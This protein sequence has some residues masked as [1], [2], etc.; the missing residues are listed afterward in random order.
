MV[1]VNV[2]FEVNYKF[3]I[4]Y[5]PNFTDINWIHDSQKFQLQMCLHIP[6]KTIPCVD[7]KEN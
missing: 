1:R 5:R 6:G 3:L 2:Y 4:A 7:Y